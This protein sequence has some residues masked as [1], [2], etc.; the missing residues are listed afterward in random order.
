MVNVENY[1]DFL[2]VKF[3]T[4]ILP[5]GK[6]TLYKVIKQP[7]FPSLKMG[8]KIVVEKHDFAEWWEDHKGKQ[9]L[10]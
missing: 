6:D 7:S 8:K 1:P 2:D 5:V 9:I 4:E 3:L 10:I